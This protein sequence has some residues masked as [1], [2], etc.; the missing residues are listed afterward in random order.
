MANR[1]VALLRAI[2]NV[3]MAPF[4]AAIEELGHADVESF[5]MSGNLIFSADGAGI[6]ALE[7][8]IGEKLD[9]VTIVRSAKE[10]ARAAKADLFPGNPAS[11]VTFLTRAAKPGE[12]KKFFALDFA[13][14]LPVLRG[15]ELYYAFPVT[16]RGKKGNVDLEK[17]L[18]I[19]GTARSARVVKRLAEVMAG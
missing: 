15:K 11:A 10:M 16:I 4:R 3:S 7:R 6:A 19:T 14:P 1:Y 18:G 12:R 5:G 13:E 2:S 17:A 8:R 9:K